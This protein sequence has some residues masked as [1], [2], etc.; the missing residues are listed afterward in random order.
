MRK[1]AI[2]GIGQVPVREHWD[3]GLR[4]MAVRAILDAMQDADV[5]NCDALYVGNMLA[6]YL[7]DQSN[8][9]ALLADYAGLQVSE[10]VS[11]EAACG[12][13]AA[14][15][16]QAVLAV[17]SGMVE[18]AIAVGVE[19][20][21]EHSDVSPT[22][23]LAT[24]ADADFEAAMGLSFVAINALLMRRYMHEYKCRK[25]NF[26]GFVIN[27]HDNARHNPHA[28][29]RQAIHLEQ[30]QHAKL[31]ADP[32]NLLDSSPIADGAAAVV[33]VPAEQ[34]KQFA[35]PAVIV[36]AC[37]VGVDTLSLSKRKD[38]L[39]LG[40]VTQSTQRAMQTAGINHT[41][42]DLLEAHDA[43]SVMTTLALEAA[44]FAEYGQGTQLANPA[45]IGINGKLP[46]STFG[47]LKARGHPVGAT[48]MYQ[49]VEA[50]T[51]LRHQAPDAIQVSDAKRAMVQNIGGSASYVVTTIL[52]RDKA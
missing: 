24:A 50:V 52:E 26:A 19:K 23:G 39:K 15:F 1:V 14:A 25:E 27:A 30:Y 47:G 12:S 17:A 35:Q 9:G 42:I 22:N 3:S 38:P 41:D 43:F 44:G 51:Q 6:G 28:M 33:I 37:E 29:F 48:G 10:A 49:I 32:I 16:R 45:T 11:L 5:R 13:G 40:A 34:A 7:S 20:L 4:E 21:T 18:S 36:N 46:L 2:V 8:L 31:I